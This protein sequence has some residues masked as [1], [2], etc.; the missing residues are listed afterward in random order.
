MKKIRYLVRAI[1]ALGFPFNVAK[2]PARREAENDRRRRQR[3]AD[4]LPLGHRYIVT[5]SEEV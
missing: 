2:W 1:P 5:R 3:K 4:K